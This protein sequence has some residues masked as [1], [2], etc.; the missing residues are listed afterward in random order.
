MA[1][2]E[3]GTE[4]LPVKNQI[5][6]LDIEDYGNEGEGVGHFNGYALFVKGAMAGERI[7]AKVIHVGKSF[8]YGRVEKIISPSPERREPPCEFAAVC[9]GC[10]LLHMDYKEQLRFKQEKVESCLMRIGRVKDIK[11]VMEP[12]I[13]MDEPYHYRNKVQLP[14]GVDENGELISGFYAIRSH[15]IVKNTDCLIQYDINEKIVALVFEW[16]RRNK[17]T[18]YDETTLKGDVRHIMTRI[19]YTTG[20]IMTVLVINKNIEN[21]K[22]LND[23]I[24]TLKPVENMTSIGLS[25]NPKNT[26]VI[27]GDTVKTIYG[28]P[29]IEDLIGDVRFRIS[30][31]SF[32]QVN[33]IQ[34]LKLYETAL[35]FAGLTGNETVWD[36]YCGIGTI[37]LF[38]AKAAKHVYGIEIVEQA[39]EDAKINAALNN[40]TNATFIAG[41]AENKVVQLMKKEE[42]AKADVVVVDP[43]RKGLEQNVI[44]TIAD[45]SPERVVYVSCEPSTLARDVAEFARLGYELKRARCTDMFPH[46]FHVETVI[47]LHR[48]DS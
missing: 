19:G 10:S 13:G 42:S 41:A 3:Q 46:S 22:I 37:S 38:L 40:I 27:F 6:E 33:P 30:A 5:I 15:R 24:E 29:Y 39:V 26:N 16:M 34:T 28:T 14:V 21:K 48:M 44:E 31:Q 2:R 12:I 25:Y 35:E 20:Q 47:A 1:K 8:G 7:L 9:G 4:G 45:M 23:L 11:S 32:F 36:L 18:A 17:L 43:P